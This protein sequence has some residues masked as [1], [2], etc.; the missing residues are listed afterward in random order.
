MRAIHRQSPLSSASLPSI[1]EAHEPALAPLLSQRRGT[2]VRE[3]GHNEASPLAHRS[4]VAELAHPCIRLAGQPRSVPRVQRFRR[5]C[6]ARLHGCSPGAAPE[7]S[8]GVAGRVVEA[9]GDGKSAPEELLVE[10]RP[11][12]HSAVY[13]LLDLAGREAAEVQI[14]G[15]ARCLVLAERIPVSTR[16]AATSVA[17]KRRSRSR[18]GPS[19]PRRGSVTSCSSPSSRSWGRRPRRSLEGSGGSLRGAPSGARRPPRSQAR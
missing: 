5:L 19:P 16:I 15:E 6:W 4:L 18:A 12:P 10:T 7:V 13:V 2:L 8:T 17:R 14:G 3:R 11:A 9:R 1:K